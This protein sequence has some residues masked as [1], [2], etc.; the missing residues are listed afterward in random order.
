PGDRR[1]SAAAGGGDSPDTNRGDPSPRC[2]LYG[3]LFEGNLYPSPL[4]R[5]GRG[6]GLRRVHGGP[7]Q[8]AQRSLP[9]RNGRRAG[10]VDGGGKTGT[11]DGAPAA[12]VGTVARCGRNRRGSAVCGK[13]AERFSAGRRGPE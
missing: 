11:A 12:P 7:A 8:D 2:R 1:R 10:G 9:R 13:A 4:R 3:L 5:G 6:A